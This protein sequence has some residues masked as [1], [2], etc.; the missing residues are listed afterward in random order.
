MRKTKF[1]AILALFI[2]TTNA[3]TFPRREGTIHWAVDGDTFELDTGE[4][5]RFIGIDTP[6]YQPWKGRIDYFGKEASEFSK[7]YLTGKKVILESDIQEKDKY[8]R[9]L[10]Y[11]YLEN[12]EFVNKVL[13]EQ[14]YAR[15]KYYRPNGR[16]R[17][18]F[19]EA[20][21]KAKENHK[22]LWANIDNSMMKV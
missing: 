5:V 7:R 22:G 3:W 2:L 6:E 12:G 18:V 8:G 17:Q 10:A 20:E 21:Q 11:V 15:A 19:K 1:L 16:Y 14:G 13:V 4:R 9:T